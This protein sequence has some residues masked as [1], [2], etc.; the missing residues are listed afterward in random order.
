MVFDEE[1]LFNK[2]V[3]QENIFDAWREYRCGKKQRPAVRVFERNLEENLLLLISDLESGS[4]EHGSYK[5]FVIHDAKRRII[6]SPSVKDHLVHRAI[7]RVLYPLYNKIFFSCSYSC[8]ENYGLHKCA[9]ATKK[10]LQQDSNNYAKQIWVAHGDIKKC[11]DSI[12][13]EKLIELAGRRIK[14][15]RTM[16]LL[17]NIIASYDLSADRKSPRGIP[18]GNLTSQLFINIYMHELDFFVK[19]KLGIKHYL[20]YADDFLIVNQDRTTLDSW[21]DEIKHFLADNLFLEIPS[22]HLDIRNALS[23]IDFVGFKFL[24]NYF[25]IK[26]KSF[27]R[28]KEKFVSLAKEYGQERIDIISLESAWQSYR[29]MLKYGCNYNKKQLLL[30][31]VSQYV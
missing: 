17:R 13:H 31:C 16:D 23:G 24:P 4:Y 9:L 18:L 21:L 10:I 11:F 28:M 1:K 2:I 15:E 14:C 7:Y 20:R 8:R 19:Q 6:S 25:V 22:D 26:P 5:Q 30:K 27:E 29:G 3:D 12:N